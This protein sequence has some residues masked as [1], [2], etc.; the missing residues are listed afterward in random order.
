MAL[1]TQLPI[2]RAAYVLLDVVT[3]AVKNMP[4]DFKRSI[5][6]KISAEC[7]EIMVLVFR[8]NVAADKLPHIAELIER[9]QVIELLLRLGMD[10]RLIL[11][12]AYAAAIEQTTSIGK[13]ANGWKKSAVRRPLHGGQGFHG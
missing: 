5:G 8:A 3:D 12:P 9:L 7:I 2:Y 11:R 1:H 13:Q 6:E 10:K 4:R